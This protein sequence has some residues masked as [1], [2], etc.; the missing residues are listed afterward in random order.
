MGAGDSTHE[1]YRQRLRKGDG[2]VSGH[3]ESERIGGPVNVFRRSS[4]RTMG[5]GSMEGRNLIDTTV[6]L[7]RGGSDGTMTRTL[8]ATGEARLTPARNCRCK[9]R[10]ITGSTGKCTEGERV[11]ERRVVATKRGNA[12]RA[13]TPHC[14]YVLFQQGRQR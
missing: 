8:R 9:V 3:N 13:K 4:S 6:P 11:A 10:A 2:E 14:W 5:E 12:C 1:A 7:R